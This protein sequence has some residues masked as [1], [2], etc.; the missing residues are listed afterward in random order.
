MNP[1]TRLNIGFLIFSVFFG[2]VFALL[3]VFMI[4]A[5]FPLF[6]GVLLAFA[7]IVT[8]TLLLGIINCFI[9]DRE[10]FKNNRFGFYTYSKNQDNR[11]IFCN[12]QN[13][14]LRT[15]LI[16]IFSSALYFLVL[17]NTLVE[18]V[19]VFFAVLSN[20]YLALGL[21]SCLRRILNNTCGLLNNTFETFP[22]EKYNYGESTKPFI[23]END[24]S[25]QHENSDAHKRGNIDL[26][27]NNDTREYVSRDH[28]NYNDNNGESD[29]NLSENYNYR[30]YGNVNQRENNNSRWR[31]NC[32]FR[33]E[34]RD[35][36]ESRFN[37]C[38]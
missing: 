14:L 24:I 6:I 27:E 5:S 21:F 8:A 38:R 32:D 35:C 30:E 28:E 18:S 7:L 22:E 20:S 2:T 34:N 25:N 13:I 12:C 37:N 4:F 9:Y 3:R 29:I 16:S 33:N 1:C 15:A 17:G 26:R 31:E 10:K 11:L 19:L 23:F 36:R